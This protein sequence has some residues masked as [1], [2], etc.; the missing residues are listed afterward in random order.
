MVSQNFVAE[1]SLLMGGI[2]RFFWFPKKMSGYI[3]LE[4]FCSIVESL[5]PWTE[6][7]PVEKRATRADYEDALAEAVDLLGIPLGDGTDLGPG[8]KKW[9]MTWEQITF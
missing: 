5:A 7:T 4:N 9:L 2:P 3:G 1:I 6:K 8:T